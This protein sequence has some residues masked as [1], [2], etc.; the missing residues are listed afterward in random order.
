[1]SSF[2]SVFVSHGAPTMAIEASPTHEFLRGLGKTLGTPNGVVCVS[3]HWERNAPAVTGAA[4]P[5]TIHDFGGFPG[6]LYAIRYPAPGSPE[7]ARRVVELAEKAGIETGI[8][9]ARGLDHGAW[10]PL[11]LMYPAADVPVV[12]LSVQS[13]RDAAH[14]RALGAALEQ[15][16]AEGVLILGS[17][18]ATHN[19]RGVFEHAEDEAPAPEAVAF[20]AWLSECVVQ[21]RDS[22]LLDWRARAPDAVQNHPTPEHFLPLFVPLGA[23]GEGARGK[24]LHRAFQFSVLSLAAFAWD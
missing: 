4:R 24:V 2:P 10:V 15:L 7:L 22:E 17:G 6:E 11:S 9:P 8:E 13:R 1:M 5:A 21:G 14:H 19:L 18:G 16:R 23:A 3:A 20:D 12:Q